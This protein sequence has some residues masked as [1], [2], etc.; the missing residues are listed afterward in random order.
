VSIRESFVEA[1]GEDQAAAIERAAEGHKNGIHDR[2]GSDPFRWAIV[3]CIGLQ[4]MSEDAYRDEHGITAPWDALKTWI[5]ASANL[6]AHDGDCDYVA[7]MLGK[8]NE[9]MP[10]LDHDEGAL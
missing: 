9:Y 1:F 3:I 4:C 6:A 10:S 5:R 8:Y 2:P 7:L